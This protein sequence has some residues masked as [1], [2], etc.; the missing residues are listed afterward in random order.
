MRSFLVLPLVAALGLAACGSS[1]DADSNGDGEVSTGE[2]VA[3]ASRMDSPRPGQYRVTMETLDFDAPN[4]PAM[5]REQMRNMMGASTQFTYCQKDQVEREASLKEMTDGMGQGNCAYN[6]FNSTGDTIALDM[7]C[8]PQ[9]AG[10]M[11][12]KMNGK[13]SE[14]GYDMTSEIEMTGMPGGGPMRMKQ[15]M[16]SER[17]GDCPAG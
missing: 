14:D 13:M 10:T 15:H 3:A 1:G 11:N 5:A 6:S 4:M 8:S 7:T 2:M 17:I 9:G 12:Y 16:V